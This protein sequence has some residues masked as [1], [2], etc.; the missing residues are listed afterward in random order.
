L[1]AAGEAVL[2]SAAARRSCVCEDSKT[3]AAAAARTGAALAR[4]KR[5]ELLDLRR[6]CFARAG[7]WLQAGKW[8][9]TLRTN[10]VKVHE[11]AKWKSVA[12][13]RAPPI[14]MYWP[15]CGGTDR[16]NTPSLFPRKLDILCP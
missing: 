9:S 14:P 13:S 15:Y 7:A 16:Q 3:G 12:F 11:T 5:A 6:P 10:K 1:T 2:H 8:H 4:R